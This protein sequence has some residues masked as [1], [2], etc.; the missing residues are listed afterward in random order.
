MRVRR[1]LALLLLAACQSSAPAP[2]KKSEPQVAM[3]ILFQ[4]PD[5]RAAWCQ[6]D[7]A[8]GLAEHPDGVLFFDAGSLL[9]V[10]VPDSP[11]QVPYHAHVFYRADKELADRSFV[12]QK[13][14]AITIDLSKLANPELLVVTSATVKMH[15]PDPA[16]PDRT[17]P[18][19]APY[20]QAFRLVPRDRAA[21]LSTLQPFRYEWK[22]PQANVSLF[23]QTSNRSDMLLTLSDPDGGADYLFADGAIRWKSGDAA[24][25]PRVTIDVE[26]G[27]KTWLRAGTYP[28][29]DAAWTEKDPFDL[30]LAG[31]TVIPFA[32]PPRVELALLDE[33]PATSLR[34]GAKFH[35]LRPEE[36]L[37]FVLAAGHPAE[38]TERIRVRVQETEVTSATPESS[39][40][41]DFSDLDA[42][43]FPVTGYVAH[44][45]VEPW[46]TTGGLYAPC[47]PLGRFEGVASAEGT[48]PSSLHLPI[49]ASHCALVTLLGKGRVDHELP[50][51]LGAYMTPNSSGRLF[52]VPVPVPW[53]PVWPSNPVNPVPT[54]PTVPTLPST[55]YVGV[56]ANPPSLPVSVVIAAIGN[57]VHP[58]SVSVQGNVATLGV[59][60]P[61]GVVRARFTIGTNPGFTPPEGLEPIQVSMNDPDAGDRAVTRAVALRLPILVSG[62]GAYVP[63]DVL[64]TPAP[65]SDWRS[66]YLEGVKRDERDDETVD[67]P[68]GFDFWPGYRTPRGGGAPK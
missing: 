62:R 68:T 47:E 44:R 24:L 50:L 23:V 8:A 54:N 4:E 60:T 65:E 66:A 42:A 11:G 32:P 31:L 22:H 25:V 38:G 29:P 18:L 49:Y 64:W 51:L 19:L 57:N 41:L 39:M 17:I 3:E 43:M 63:S 55:G 36:T 33:R 34:V 12:Q 58:V 35:G 28:V 67:A 59:P 53:S 30:S 56:P 27:G 9:R 5:H 1:G 45:L 2:A 10:R 15:V 6:K 26:T 52:P 7:A 46:R 16:V 20:A 21:A 40:L 61:R 14:G 37:R 13:D 48:A